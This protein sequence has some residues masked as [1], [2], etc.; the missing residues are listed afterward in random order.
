MPFKTILQMSAE[1]LDRH[2]EQNIIKKK[3]TISMS[4]G[5]KWKLT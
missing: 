3:L 4:G 1:E 5:L 2:I